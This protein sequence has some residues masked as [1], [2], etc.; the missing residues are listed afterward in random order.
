MEYRL[1]GHFHK[2][3]WVRPT[4]L[5][6]FETVNDWKERNQTDKD[7]DDD[8]DNDEGAGGVDDDDDDDGGVGGGTGGN[9]DD[10]HHHHNSSSWP[11]V[12]H[13]TLTIHTSVLPGIR[14]AF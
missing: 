8:D 2:C 1:K 7:V 13:Q 3:F 9:C 11:A 14:D 6:Y 12:L 10:D 5:R 4:L